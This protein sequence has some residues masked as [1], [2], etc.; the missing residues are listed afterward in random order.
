MGKTIGAKCKACRRAGEKLIL[1]GDRCTT[2]KCAIVKRNYPPGFHGPKG[3]KRSTDY[4]LQLLEKQKAKWQYNLREKQFRIAF[5][6]AKAQK[7]NVVENFFRLLET[8]F[9]NVVFRAGFADSRTQARQLVNHAHFLINGN[10]VNIPSYRLKEGDVV[11]IRE[12]SKTNKIFKGLSD[13]LTTKEAPGWMNIDGKKLDI[14]ILHNPSAKEVGSNINTQ[15]IV[16]FYS[17]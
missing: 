16:E 1:K 14:K 9:D 12:T 8:R 10:K 13:K 15:L 3:K 7:G 17:R 11:S 2:P 5:D 6:D 4:G